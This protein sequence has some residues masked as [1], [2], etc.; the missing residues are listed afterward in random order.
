[1][2]FK[3]LTGWLETDLPILK[4]NFYLIE[5]IVTELHEK[6][7]KVQTDLT[8]L[9]H[10]REDD[11]VMLLGNMSLYNLEHTQKIKIGVKS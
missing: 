4:E 7:K 8:S 1:M 3:K 2:L 9:L 5:K 11:S 6:T 10:A